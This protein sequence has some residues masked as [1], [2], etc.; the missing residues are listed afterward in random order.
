VPRGAEA[1]RDLPAGALRVLLVGRPNAGKSSLFNRLTG[2]SAQVGNFPGVTVDL[3]EGDVILP[4]GAHAT[5]VDLPGLY[6]LSDDVPEG[7]DEGIA[8]DFLRAMKGD[9]EHVLL[10]QIAD[11]TQLGA[12]LGLFRAVR[13]QFPASRALFVASQLDLL[14]RDGSV[15]DV[16][17]LADA[18]GSAAVSANAREAASRDE[19]LAAIEEALRHD[20]TALTAFD[21]TQVAKAVVH[22]PEQRTALSPRERSRKIDRVL[23]HPFFGPLLFVVTMATLFSSVFLIADPVAK[24][25]DGA[26]ALL[27]GWARRVLGGG[28]LGSAVADGALGGAGTVAAFLPQ[29]VLLVAGMELLEASGYLARG[30]FLVDRLLRVFGLGGKAFV[31][32][33]TGHACAVPAITATR[34]LRDPKERLTTILVLPLMTCSARLPVYGLLIA[35]FVGGGALRKAAVFT[36]LYAFAIVA[37]LVAAV[38]L[39]RTVTKGRGLPLALEMPDYRAP[40]LGAVLRRC[41]RE[42]KEFLRR[43]GT[44]IVVM[45]L[46]LWAALKIPARAGEE[47]V[48]ARSVAAAVGHALEPV[49]KPLGYDWRIN[50]G[51]IASF[52]ARELMVGTFGIIH[53]VE[54]ADNEPAPLVERMQNA[55]DA[56]GRPS[57]GLPTALSLL[58]FFVFACQ[59]MSTLSAIYRETRSLRWPLFVLGYTY[60]LAYVA[61]LITYQTARLFS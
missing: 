16:A 19:V 10:V 52:G 59:C 8:R 61:A 54:G 31:P 22:R 2:G 37:G 41:G 51:L 57:Y 43:V 12:S 1:R 55:K 25:C 39:R 21:P 42:A 4:S 38:V 40:Q 3:L 26:V 48:E 6:A 7:T 9:A 14:E 30:A 35:A 18:I 34:V 46:V 50:V 60:T 23:L 15:L 49:T 33:L 36:G 13:E 29:V 28:L 17:A 24:A 45:A 47:P 20:V 53:G 32:L 27:G 11:S 44:V 58:V 5:V 56:D